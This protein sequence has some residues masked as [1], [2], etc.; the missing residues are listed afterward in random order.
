MDSHPTSPDP[1]YVEL[2]ESD[3]KTWSDYNGVYY[4]P[5]SLHAISGIEHGNSLGELNGFLEGAEEFDMNDKVL[6]CQLPHFTTFYASR[7]HFL[8][9]NRGVLIDQRYPRGGLS[10]L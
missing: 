5:R 6:H 7:S 10:A 4:H 9:A 2:Q 3:I 8:K 1:A